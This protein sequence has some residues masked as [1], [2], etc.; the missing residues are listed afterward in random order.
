MQMFGVS[1]QLFGNPALDIFL[2][3]KQAFLQ[4][5]QIFPHHQCFIYL[6]FPHSENFFSSYENFEISGY[7]S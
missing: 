3:L 1:K 5:L 6:L 2:E 7:V 4:A